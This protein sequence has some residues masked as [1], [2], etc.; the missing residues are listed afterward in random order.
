MAFA[1]IYQYPDRATAARLSV[2]PL[3][4]TLVKGDEV[5]EAGEEGADA[6]LLLAARKAESEFQKILETDAPAYG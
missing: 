2:A 6:A 3:A 5:V 1:S 4:L